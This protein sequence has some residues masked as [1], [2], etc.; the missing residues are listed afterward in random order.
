MTLKEFRKICEADINSIS[1][2]FEKDRQATYNRN[3]ELIWDGE[4]KLTSLGF[5]PQGVQQQPKGFFEKKLED[6]ADW[7]VI[8]FYT[9]HIGSDAG[10][11]DTIRTFVDIVLEK[12]TE[13]KM[14]LLKAYNKIDNLC[15]LNNNAIQTVNLQIQ[16]GEMPKP[17]DFFE[18][19][20]K[21]KDDDF[22]KDANEMIDALEI[23]RNAI[24]SQ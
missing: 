24:C 10:E 7:K 21:T 6:C 16:K 12:P 2:Y 19:Y 14:S 23:I 1:Y 8:S 22:C 11:I 3:D 20:K 18:A 15:C 17:I 13:T 9:D 4:E 5:Y